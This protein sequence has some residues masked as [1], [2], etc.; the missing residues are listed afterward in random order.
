MPNPL[1]NILPINYDDKHAAI[2][3]KIYFTL[4]NHMLIYT[5]QLQHNKA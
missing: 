2:K 1:N 3:I 5:T 4:A